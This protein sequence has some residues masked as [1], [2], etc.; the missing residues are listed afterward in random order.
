MNSKLTVSLLT[1]L[2]AFA[3]VIVTSHATQAN[4]ADLKDNHT[5]DQRHPGLVGPWYGNADFTRAKGSDLLL[6]LAPSFDTETGFGSSW[7]AMWEGELLA[8]ASG[9]IAFYVS[10]TG[11]VRVT[12]AGRTVLDTGE[13][14]DTGTV[15][16]IRERAYPVQ[17]YY[18]HR[19]PGKGDFR[20]EWNWPG[21][22]REVVPS[23]YLCHSLDREVYWNW[24]PEPNPATIDRSGFIRVS[25]KQV[26][27]YGEPGRFAGWPANNGI[28]HWGNEILVGFSLGYHKRDSGGGHAI[29]S[30]RPEGPALARS[31][32]GGE[33]W[34]LE[35][36]DL[37]VDRDLAPRALREPIGFAH[38]DFAMRCSGD[39]FIISYDRGR[40]WQGRYEFSGFSFERLTSRT[41]YL[42]QDENTCTVFLS[43]EVKGVQVDEYSDRA[44]CARTTDGGLTW[45]FLG[46]MTGE[47]IGVRSVMPTTVRVSNTHLVSALRR[48]I[49]RGLGQER[50]PVTENWIDAYESTDNG[51]TWTLLSKITH[52]DTGKHNGN[53]PALVRLRDGRLVI[54]YGY[55]G[56]PYG[57]RARISEDNGATWGA[58]LHLRDDAATWDLGYCRMLQRPDGKLVTLYYYNTPERIEQHIAAT[59]WDPNRVVP[60][61]SDWLN[62]EAVVHPGP[63]IPRLA[64]GSIPEQ[65]TSVERFKELKEAGLTHH[66]H[67]HY[68]SADEAARALDAAQA[69]GIKVI[70][71]CPELRT[72]P[73]DTVKRFM[74]HPA[75]EA[76]FVGDEPHDEEGF[77]TAGSWADRIRAVDRSHTCY[78][79]L[80]PGGK[81]NTVGGAPYETYLHWYATYFKPKVVSFD[82]YSIHVDRSNG[83]I[84]VRPDW[85]D[86]LECIS[87]FS[88]DIGKPFWAFALS[89]AH[90]IPSKTYA[91]PTIDHLRLQVYSNL[92]YGAQGIQY[93]TF[94]TPK[95]DN[96]NPQDGAEHY[97]TGPIL[98][99]GT[100]TQIYDVI[101]TVNEEIKNLS[102]VFQ[103]S[104]VTWVRHVGIDSQAMVTPLTDELDNTPIQAVQGL[105]GGIL[106]AQHENQG[107]HYLVVVNYELTQN[108]L[109]ITTRAPVRRVLKSGA[110]IEA[111]EVLTLLPGDISIYTWNGH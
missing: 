82:H 78:L 79:N 4:A 41:D 64:W 2:L 80:M 7:S 16:M 27:V 50:P 100:R 31:L 11:Q 89:V 15:D 96:T 51:V 88:R 14:L 12:I 73:E 108:H 102:F 20:I 109:A 28:W 32:D 39:S 66:F 46:W 85:Y 22:A 47:P 40:N 59:I 37:S 43:A 55:R 17:V 106:V 90:R 30:A 56:V 107:K 18:A 5:A 70:V 8:P 21:H 52:T 54:A 71:T 93:F 72:L 61:S 87:A 97:Y 67:Y 10:T 44:F 75:L 60:D 29:D 81:T 105:N 65:H 53:P 25:G 3:S 94:W 91:E 36:P 63:E 74:D 99:D 49:D 110:T 9:P 98:P 111:E 57:I 92:A 42:V 86:N 23:D 48:R 33:T 19:S 101:K 77:V 35:Q 69:A 104:T 62:T 84:L 13:G 58:A 95:T 45:Q 76:Y 103:G 68:S 6:T 83:N 34:Q 24:R 1:M 38:P 26:L